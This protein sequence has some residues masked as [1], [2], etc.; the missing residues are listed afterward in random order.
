MRLY[1]LKRY[2]GHDRFKLALA[3]ALIQAAN[4]AVLLVAKI[5][6][7]SADFAFLLTQLAFAG[8]IGAIASMRFEVLVFQT[9]SRMTYAAIVI[10]IVATA[11]VIP[12]FFASVELTN[13]VMG[14]DFTLSVL[15]IPMMIG[16]SFSAI[17]T[18]AYLQVGLLNALVAARAV[19]AGALV[20]V[21]LALL[22][23]F[24]SPSGSTLLAL[25]G[26][27]YAIPSALWLVW[28]ILQTSPSRNDPPAFYLPGLGLFKRSL[29]LTVSTGVNSIYVNLPLLVAYG[30]QS[31]SFVA[32]FGLMLRAFTAPVTLIGQVIGRLFLA[33]ALRWSLLPENS[34]SALSRLI[35][36]AMV[37]S[38]GG[39]LL[40]SPPLIGLLWLY[41]AELNIVHIEL[42]AYLFV[43]GLGQ[44]VV[45]P[46][47]QVRVALK[48]ERTFLIF[49]TLRLFTLAL[50]LYSLAAILPYELAFM[51]TALCLYAAYIGFIF[52]RVSYY[53]KI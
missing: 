31:V 19:Q 4:F 21:T 40:I 17:H 20:L 38:L 2:I 42:A 10:P 30:T 14:Q 37:Q 24:Y 53:K 7:P 18:F 36:H 5:T 33:D 52:Q 8:I 23:G 26:I 22:S 49:D 25:I 43:A 16:L 46:V 27:G 51:V 50:G 39:Y 35:S 11:A 32:D 44:S 41:R 3:S 48:D 34:T 15:S 6:I 45:N 29:S 47:S 12:T 13:M 28:F 1:A 9:H